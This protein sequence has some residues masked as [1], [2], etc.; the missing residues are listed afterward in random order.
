MEKIIE[1]KKINHWRHL[2]LN[3]NVWVRAAYQECF[4]TNNEA[5]GVTQPQMSYATEIENIKQKLGELVD[6]VLK[7]TAYKKEI[8]KL[9]SKV[10]NKRDNEKVYE[11]R[12][13]SLRA[14]PRLNTTRIPRPHLTGRK[15]YK[16]ITNFRLGDA[17][18]GNKGPKPVV[19]CPICRKGRNNET[20]LVLE[21]DQVQNIR[22]YFTQ[23]INIS[24]YCNK[25]EASEDSDNKLKQF[26]S[27]TK[28]DFNQQ[29][30][31]LTQLLEKHGELL[32]SQQLELPITELTEECPK[33]NYKSKSQTGIKIHKTKVHK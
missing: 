8:N 30:E 13:H 24:K 2:H 5:I 26:L 3:T 22:D 1:K 6:P 14:Y 17:G 10:H 11:M 4:K 7:R 15:G 19:T 27:D 21:C 23:F 20:H 16:I 18:L 9:L 25:D 32:S 29:A 12:Q 28:E 31:F 33:C